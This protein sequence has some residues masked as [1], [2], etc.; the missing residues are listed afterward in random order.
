MVC[1][2]FP[3]RVA[4][5]GRSGHAY[6]LL[7]RDEVPYMID[8]HLFLGRSVTLS[9]SDGEWVIKGLKCDIVCVCVG[10]YGGVPQSVVDDEEDFMR[11][12]HSSSS[13]L[14]SPSTVTSYV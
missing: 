2:W 4:R 7:S 11:H 3:G 13:D 6:S 1:L 10:V 8:L 14:V 12:A 5:A 9:G